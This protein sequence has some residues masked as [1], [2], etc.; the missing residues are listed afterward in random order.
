ML[1]VVERLIRNNFVNYTKFR[2]NCVEKKD[3]MRRIFVVQFDHL[4][5]KVNYAS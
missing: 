2:F 4:N 1:G 5:N 3:N